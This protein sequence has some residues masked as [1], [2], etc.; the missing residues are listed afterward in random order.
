M[1]TKANKVKNN[2]LDENVSGKK[3]KKINNVENIK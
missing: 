1:S 3:E 2:L